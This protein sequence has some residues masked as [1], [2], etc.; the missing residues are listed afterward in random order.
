MGFDIG[1]WRY[2]KAPLGGDHLKA[3]SKILNNIKVEEVAEL[4]V[5][6]IK[7][8]IS[9]KFEMQWWHKDKNGNWEGATHNF[10]IFLKTQL[11]LVSCYGDLGD[12]FEDFIDIMT[13]FKCPG[14]DPQS[15]TRHGSEFKS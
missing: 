4:P 10:Q 14:F 12:N 9:E 11:V 1:F 7:E 8:R 5:D 2:N 3:Y 6:E 15:G 13:E